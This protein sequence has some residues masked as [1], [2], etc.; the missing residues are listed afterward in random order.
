MFTV[1]RKYRNQLIINADKQGASKNREK[2]KILRFSLGFVL[3]TSG[4]H[5]HYFLEI[6]VSCIV[7]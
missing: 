5:S 7:F 2:I 6:F 1:I 4:L 3:T